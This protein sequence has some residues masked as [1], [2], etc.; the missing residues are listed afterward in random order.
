MMYA[1]APDL[2]EALQAAYETRDDM[3]NG[4]VSISHRAYR[5]MLRAIAKATKP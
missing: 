5:M 2:L 1:A 3:P 4:K